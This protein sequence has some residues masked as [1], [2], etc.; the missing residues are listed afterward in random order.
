MT[1]LDITGHRFGR[2]QLFDTGYRYR[3]RTSDGLYLHMS[4]ETGYLTPVRH[5][6]W[7]G[8][9]EQMRNALELLPEFTRQ[10][11]RPIPVEPPPPAGRAS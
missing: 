3:L 9:R 2:H 4:V 11:L 7:I 5:H 10:Q 6:A 1:L 8:T